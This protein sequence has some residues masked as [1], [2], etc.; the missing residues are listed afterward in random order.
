M[1]CFHQGVSAERL[2]ASGRSRR[3]AGLAG[4]RSVGGR[5]SGCPGRGEVGKS[6]LKNHPLIGGEVW[7]AAERS[8]AW[9]RSHISPC[10]ILAQP[11]PTP[12]AWEGTLPQPSGPVPPCLLGPPSKLLRILSSACLLPACCPQSWHFCGLMGSYVLCSQ[13][14]VGS[15]LSPAAFSLCDLEAGNP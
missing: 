7:E 13:T 9:E 15:N 6:G 4:G 11:P 3:E 10:A 1:S 2:R 5:V 12:G 8:A 14:D